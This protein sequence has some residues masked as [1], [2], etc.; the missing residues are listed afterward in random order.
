[1]VFASWSIKTERH[2]RNCV[3]MSDQPG[4]QFFEVPSVRNEAGSQSIRGHQREYFAKPR[5]QCRLSSSE[6][7]L[8]DPYCLLGLFQKRLEKFHRHEVCR[9]V[10]KG[11]VVS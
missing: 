3:A 4:P 2:V 1:M 6:R 5:I 11:I 9:S 7:D 8:S 10:V